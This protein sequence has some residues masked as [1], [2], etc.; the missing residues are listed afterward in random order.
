MEWKYIEPLNDINYI[1]EVESIFKIQFPKFFNEIIL[2]N[3]GGY[4]AQQSLLTPLNNQSVR[5]KINRKI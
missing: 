1:Q 4:P 5:I 2:N 3:N